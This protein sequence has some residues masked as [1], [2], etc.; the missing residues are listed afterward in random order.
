VES[1]KVLI[2]DDSPAA[3]DGL[4]SIL[5]TPPDI[6]VVGEAADGLEATAKAE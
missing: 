2:V 3:R 5:R 4:Q 1:I 6:E